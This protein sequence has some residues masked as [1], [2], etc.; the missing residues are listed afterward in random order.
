MFVKKKTTGKKENTENV[1]S[2]VLLSVKKI[3]NLT[4]GPRIS[5]LARHAHSL[6]NDHRETRSLQ[7]L[8]K[9]LMLS[10]VNYNQPNRNF[11]QFICV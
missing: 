1:K 9:V 6:V 10:I 4:G 2:L 8:K 7:I 3:Y 11:G 5:S